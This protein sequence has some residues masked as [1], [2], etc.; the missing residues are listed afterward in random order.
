M[1]EETNL[2]TELD[3][4]KSQS[5][6]NLHEVIT[7]HTHNTTANLSNCTTDYYLHQQQLG[8]HPDFHYNKHNE[9]IFDD[10]KL[11]PSLTAV[12]TG[13]EATLNLGNTSQDEVLVKFDQDN[14]ELINCAT[15]RALIVQ[16]TSPEII[17]YNLICDF[18]LTYRMF[19]NSG[20]IMDLLLTRLIWSLQYINSQS[21]SNVKLGK[22]VLLRTFVVLRHWII[23]YFVDD[24]DENNYLCDFF[25][26]TL[27][28]ITKESNLV[29]TT[30]MEL[31]N[32]DNSIFI[33][34]II[35]DLKIHWLN[36][37][38]QFWGL[39]LDLQA[40]ISSHGIINYT[41]PL[42]PSQNISHIKLSKSNTELSFH[43][44]AS[45]RRSA[46]LS[47]YNQKTIHKM[48]IFDDDDRKQQNP[49]YSVNNLF[50]QHQSSRLSIAYKLQQH[51][52]DQP[53]L[54]G[55]FE[56]LI[57]APETPPRP[58]KNTGK[59]TKSKHLHIKDSALDLKKTKTIKEHHVSI[60]ETNPDEPEEE[61]ETEEQP[62][63]P[64]R[65]STPD[66]SDY[67]KV[68]FSTN[69]NVK[70]PTS[71]IVRIVPPTPAKKMDYVLV[72]SGITSPITSPKRKRNN[73]N[74]TGCFKPPSTVSSNFDPTR[75]KSV[76]KL[77]EGFKKSLTTHKSHGSFSDS[78]QV[79]TSAGTLEGMNKI[80]T[81]AINVI[82]DCTIE[83]R[84]DVLSARII[85]E[86]EFLIRHYV[87]NDTVPNIF[88]SH[89]E[90][91]EEVATK[92]SQD[93]SVMDINNLSELNIDKIDNLINE[94]EQKPTT[95]D[96]IKTTTPSE[97]ILDEVLDNQTSFP[98]AA[99]I[100]WNDDINFDGS[101]DDKTGDTVIKTKVTEIDVI[102]D[103]EDMGGIE[104]I[105]DNLDEFEFG[106]A[107]VEEPPRF[108]FE[109]DLETSTMSSSTNF[110]QCDVE[111]AD[112]GIALSP[113]RV[114]P[115]YNKRVSM[116]SQKSHGSGVLKRD[117]M[118]SYFSY[119]S[120]FSMSNESRH[121]S[122]LPNA[123]GLKKKSG[124]NN[125][126]G[127][128]VKSIGI[129]NSNVRFSQVSR[130]TSKS[131]H[132]SVNGVRFSTLCAL[133]ELPFNELS[134]TAKSKKLSTRGTGSKSSTDMADSSIFSVAMKS[135]KSNSIKNTTNK[136][137]S[138]ASSNTTKN[139]VAIPGI[140]PFVLKELAA[141]PDETLQ[142]SENPVE[143]AFLKL[144]GKSSSKSVLPPPEE[145]V[146][147]PED[148]EHT[149]DIL[150]AIDNANTEDAI[151]SPDLTEEEH[152]L[153]PPKPEV[154][155]TTI[156]DDPLLLTPY[157]SATEDID[158]IEPAT[159]TPIQK[160]QSSEPQTNTFNDN[161]EDDF[162]FTRPRMSISRELGYDTPKTILDNY[163]PSKEILSVEE[164]MTN[165]I[166]ISFVLSF[167][168]KSLADHFTMVE[169]DM[170]QEI[171]WRELIE[172]KW[173]KELTPV[174][175]WLEIIV[176]DKYYDQ[177]KGVNLVIARFNL[178]VN[179]IISEI[180]LTKGAQERINII[181]RFIH[182]AQNCYA[183]QN[184]STLMQIILA[185]TS[186]RI[187]KLKETW[188]NLSPGDILM[189]KNLEEI[190]SPFKNFLN[191]RLCINQMKPSRGC[192]PF[193]GLYLS[194]L[195]FNAER[196]GIIKRQDE[197]QEKLINFSKFRTS[198]HVVKSLS[199]CIE[200]SCNYNVSVQRELLSKC[201][202]IRSLDEEEMKYCLEVLNDE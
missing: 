190:A 17:D 46:M 73:S 100:N 82:D 194:D 32:N 20:E 139:S 155:S 80:I 43:T 31:D 114:N 154:D 109:Q 96:N 199:Q 88:N 127:T 175:S 11:F 128:D 83:N 21:E 62:E 30:T 93:V 89:M 121:S 1:E 36:L 165:D 26:T 79:N 50:L 118:K 8:I 197:T 113:Q 69:G 145:Q 150:D 56:E 94:K 87:R 186:E 144:E 187:Q 92:K 41:L 7:N 181:S 63:E 189:H 120:A 130:S 178:M 23:N 52:Q 148:V 65:A 27:N 40:I 147:P 183:L 67:D 104:G 146:D 25:S 140:S 160:D 162:N 98:K 75:K 129:S 33:C 171:D 77:M 170:L 131:S 84:V 48:L 116:L 12:T 176:N 68:G 55:S 191:L 168:S 5:I 61:E 143:F 57:P 166:H 169:R 134:S 2:D 138:L 122:K 78:S 105:H 182:I 22:L 136:E 135:N 101:Q 156:L 107:K 10:E 167:D 6:H 29:Q 85:D 123:T 184:Y 24:F 133:T 151:G 124:F 192:I 198:V 142:S 74:T 45:Y 95:L 103:L 193:M 158:L 49:Q 115:E 34:K 14:P 200:W 111:I 174:N 86:L 91:E 3:I 71:K 99:S 172:L 18:F 4:R 157:Q 173:N 51:Q 188:R 152:P 28:K 70:L 126:R 58:K 9:S 47:L 53:K 90:D 196:P 38:N 185:L 64:I 16:L 13:H 141:I 149:E 110:S 66:N 39:E 177:N 153:T 106:N 179:W 81:N 164:I 15:L 195:T 42:Y 97:N 59:I 125:L 19:S 102:E 163:E 132:R 180:L 159:S 108:S 202:Y 54:D 112:L 72:G 44:N 37:I 119:D 60:P 137:T 161:D 76:K 117:S 35:G 201:L